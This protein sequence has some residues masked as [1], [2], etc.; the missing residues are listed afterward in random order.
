MARILGEHWPPFPAPG[1]IARQSSRAPGARPSDADILKRL[2]H[3]LDGTRKRTRRAHTRALAHMP[4]P[5][6]KD[7]PLMVGPSLW[8]WRTKTERISSG[9]AN[10]SCCRTSGRDARA[11][12]QRLMTDRMKKTPQLG[13]PHR[14]RCCCCCCDDEKSLLSLS[15]VPRTILLISRRSLARPGV[16]ASIGLAP[17]T[18]GGSAGFVRA[19]LGR[20]PRNRNRSSSRRELAFFTLLVRRLYT[21]QAAR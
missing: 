20:V 14:L 3:A 9:L 10:S 21:H 15:P 5:S 8:G 7:C 18:N 2:S 13:S 4:P 19:F 17:T 6:E 16:R 12:W 11:R 1:R